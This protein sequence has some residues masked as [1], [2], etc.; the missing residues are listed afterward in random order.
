MEETTMTAPQ[1]YTPTNGARTAVLATLGLVGVVAVLIGV[2]AVT[3]SLDDR[4]TPLVVSLVGMVVA[5]VPATLGAV[6]SERA[7]RDIRN[8]T[9]AAKAREGAVQAI[10]EEQV[11]T[12]TGPVVTAEVA[13]LSELVQINRRIRDALEGPEGGR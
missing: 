5:V 12:R 13:A 6:F 8:G 2:L 11:L 4:A 1:H 9:V 3:G 10:R 7:S